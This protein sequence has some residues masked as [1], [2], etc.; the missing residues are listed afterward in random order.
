MPPTPR[1][2]RRGKVRDIYE[3]DADHL[4]IV[5]TDRLS[6]FDVVLPDPIPGK[7]KVLASIT[8]FWMRK[9]AGIV[10]NHL[11]DITPPSP[12][13]RVGGETYSSE[14]LDV[15]KKCEV[16]PVEC[17]VR[18][19]ITGSGWKDYLKTG[20]V[21]GY[22]LPAGLK[23]C[24]ELPEPLFT[25]STKAEAGHDQNISPA[26]AARLIGAETAK[27]IEEL[28]VK[29]YTAGREHARQRGI[30]IADTKFEFGI[31]DGEILLID[32]VLTP[33]SSRFWP[34]DKY[35]PGH[36][37][38]SFDKQIIRNYLETLDWDKADPGP[39]LPPEIIA[40]T[41]RAYAEILQRLTT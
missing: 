12:P 33:D 34:E 41:Q 4:L 26:E 11:T 16:I 6:A 29:I 37:Q 32:E 17:I 15:V 14:Q 38:P 36:D 5:T 40:R 35:E 19:F 3:L 39:K 22:K 13:N 25:P 30:L 27:R 21:C 10:G 23:Q 1:F 24:A 7:G 20:E 18:G 9:F 28:A 31:R 8:R 2:L